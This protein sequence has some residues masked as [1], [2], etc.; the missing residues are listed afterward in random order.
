MAVGNGVEAG[1]VDGFFHGKSF[2]GRGLKAEGKPRH[3]FGGWDSRLSIFDLFCECLFD[4]V[5][6]CRVFLK[7]GKARDDHTA[8]TIF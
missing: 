5:S 4:G 3:R 1:G 7:C 6:E 8:F 2:I